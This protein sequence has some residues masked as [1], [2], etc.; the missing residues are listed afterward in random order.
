MREEC[1]ATQSKK[2]PY[3]DLEATW[4]IGKVYLYVC[5][6]PNVGD[7]I[8]FWNHSRITVGTFQHSLHAI[9]TSFG[10]VSQFNRE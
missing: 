6:N 9:R 10:L 4:L 5:I 2:R 7:A 3:T 1:Y 8:T